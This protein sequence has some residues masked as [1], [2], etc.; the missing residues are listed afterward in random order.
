MP[1]QEWS[2]RIWLVQLTDEPGF[3]DELGPL[4]DRI[5]TMDPP[6]ALV[7]DLSDVTQINSSNLSQ[8]LRLRKAMVERDTPIRLASPP[9]AVWS[10][11]IMTGLD[12]VFYFSQD[13]SIALT[14][15][16]LAQK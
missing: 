5:I 12:K 14:E 15:L 1:V 16:Q 8:L 3:S 11:F 4:T 9:D 13:T 2:E 6:P 10:V 7:I